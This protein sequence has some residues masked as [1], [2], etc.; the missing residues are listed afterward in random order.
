MVRICLF[1]IWWAM[2]SPALA[3]QSY[4]VMEQQRSTNLT[5][6][7]KWTGVLSRHDAQQSETPT[8]YARW[9]KMLE[10]LRGKTQ[11]EQLKQVNAWGN[12]HPYIID[13]LNWGLQDYWETPLEFIDVSGDC[14]DY[15]ITKYYSLRALG[16]SDEKMRI[17]IV[18]DLN[19]GGIIHAVLG[20]YEGDTLWILD[21]QN[22]QV[23]PASRILHYVPVYG[24]NG[25]AWWRYLPKNRG[26]I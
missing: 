12:E 4:F 3:E 20:V 25:Q 23:M 19:L 8:T 24:V 13:Q 15:A 11:Q 9:Q 2:A 22:E 7:H 5:P 14:E 26:S 1:F 21:N 10:S 16:V 18:Q 6:F 17:M